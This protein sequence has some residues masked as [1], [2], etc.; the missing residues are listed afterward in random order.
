M[1]G[2]VSGTDGLERTLIGRARGGDPAAF[3]QII[4]RYG[5]AVHRL[6][7]R[8]LGDRVSADE[9]AQETFVRAHA[10]ILT[11]RDEDRLLP[12]LLGIARRVSLEQ[13]RARR[14]TTSLDE[15]THS[16]L[17]AVR[18]PE[19]LL[20]TREAQEQVAAAIAEL[21]AERRTAL[22]L[23]VEQGLG[24]DAIAEALGWSLS[25]VKNEI[26]R[27]RL[28]LRA[29]IARAAGEDGGRR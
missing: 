19:S 12:W 27:A 15:V 21:P 26:H 11:L 5:P 24:Y 1:G 4:E 3:R 16:T 6:L 20:L 13:H 29:A 28:E 17:D 25:K 9:S 8:L 18:T 14:R 23:R 10:R 2:V 22:L 7:V